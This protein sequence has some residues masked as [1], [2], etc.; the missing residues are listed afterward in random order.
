MIAWC[1]QL[2]LLG[3]IP[4]GFSVTLPEKQAAKASE[5][6]CLENFLLFLLGPF[7]HS[8]QK[9]FL[10]FRDVKGVSSWL[11][12]SELP[13][14]FKWR[15]YHPSCD[16][17][18]AHNYMTWSRHITLSQQVAVTPR[19]INSSPLKIGRNPKGQDRL[20]TI[21]FSGCKLLVS[22]RVIYRHQKPS[23]KASVFRGE[24]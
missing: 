24:L 6:K 4:N 1:F 22:G 9:V 8:S 20:P 2:S 16:I 3:I 15:F 13:G 14:C 7:R 17:H 5:Q 12:W 18:K 21:N 19:K 11:W 23:S 10:N